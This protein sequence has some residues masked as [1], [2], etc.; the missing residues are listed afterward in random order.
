[1][2]DSPATTTSVP[3][4]RGARPA[5]GA[6][7]KLDRLRALLR[8]MFQLD[9]GDLDFGLYRIM[10]SGSTC[11]LGTEFRDPFACTLS[12]VRDGAR[13]E[14][15]VDLPETFNCLIG[16][17]AET[18]N[19]IDGLLA[20]TGTDADG[21]KCLVIWRNLDETDCVALD[22]WFDDNRERFAASL[23]RIYINGDHTLNAMR[24][25]DETWTAENMEPVFRTLMFDE[26]N[27]GE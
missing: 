9:R 10:N 15:P 18:R 26:G 27:G 8:E 12:V 4:S 2:D 22:A 7:E 24:R 16:L 25:P 14:V 20:I 1:M 6:A 5:P 19:R 11:L 17:R 3:A 23:D 13:C 21:R